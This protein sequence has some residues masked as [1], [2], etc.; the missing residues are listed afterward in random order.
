MATDGINPYQAPG[1]D[2]ASLGDK[3]DSSG[4]YRQP[5]AADYTTDTLVPRFAALWLDNALAFFTMFGLVMAV[6]KDWAATQVTVFLTA[7]YAYFFVSEGLTGRTIGKAFFSLVVVQMN[8]QRCTWWQAFIRTAL[9]FLELNPVI[10]GALPAGISALMSP[11]RQRIGDRL[12]GT[13]VIRS[14]HARRLREQ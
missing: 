14:R 13:L 12:A 3:D 10:F 6:P 2:V 1:P 5:T 8:G 9:R 11:H 7:Y 4:S